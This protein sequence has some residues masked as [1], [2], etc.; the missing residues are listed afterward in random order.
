MSTIWIY[1]SNTGDTLEFDNIEPEKTMAQIKLKSGLGWH[2]PFN[3]YDDIQTYYNQNKAA[4]PGW[5]APVENA[6]QPPLAQ[7]GGAVSSAAGAV[8]VTLGPS[9][10][11]LG[12]WLLRIGAIL[13][14]IVL[15]GVGVS[16]LTGNSNFVTNAL[17]KVP[18]IV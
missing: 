7:A 16:H 5:K 10:I 15:I 4:T 18:L 2:G 9:G 3:T 17:G 6:N 8:G 12:A 1:N 13:L 14:G 11:N